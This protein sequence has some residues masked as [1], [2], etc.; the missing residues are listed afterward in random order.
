MPEKTDISA[1]SLH[2]FEKLLG[3][4]KSLNAGDGEHLREIL[5]Q[6]PFLNEARL[7]YAAWQSHFAPEEFIK[8]LPEAALYTGHPLRFRDLIRER[9]PQ[10]Q[11][12]ETK[13]RPEKKLSKER[14]A[15]TKSM[16]AEADAHKP[17]I[18][19]QSLRPQTPDP[20][21]LIER[22]LK[23]EPR[24]SVKK[25]YSAPEDVNPDKSLVDEG[26]LVSETLARIHAGQGHYKKAI[27]IY[28]KLSLKFPGKS[29]YFAARIKDLQEKLHDS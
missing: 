6:W 17:A 10:E 13:D 29:S 14:S 24:I 21:E 2:R 22:F 18:I 19:D 1:R 5:L 27:E 23:T 9:A 20:D 25:D 26:G 15:F 11:R 28:N 8:S 16:I 7:L 3:E 4:G 12:D